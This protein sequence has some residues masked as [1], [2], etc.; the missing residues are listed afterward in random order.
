MAFLA[1]GLVTQQEPAGAEDPMVLAASD[2]ACEPG[3]QFNSCR[4]QD[5]AALLAGNLAAVLPLGDNQYEIGALSDYL[6]A[7]DQSWGVF[8]PQ[9]YPV[10]GNHEYKTLNAA[11]YFRQCGG[12][13]AK[14]LL[15]LQPR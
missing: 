1:A 3:D 2:I 4:D 5:T 11:G 14:G 8:K 12:R 6:A 9:T 13:S 10:P 7:Y 15:Q